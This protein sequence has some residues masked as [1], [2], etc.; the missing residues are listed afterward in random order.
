M[1]LTS[2]TIPSMIGGVSQQ[3]ASVRLMSQIEDALNCDLSPAR[4]AGPRPP[5]QF[6]NVLGSDIPDNA[7]FHSIIRDSRERYIVA[8]YPGRVRV[9]NHETGKEYVVIT[10]QPSL[11]YLTTQQNPW[12]S[13]R[14]VTVDDYT[15]IVNRD[16]RVAMAATLTP[17]SVVGSVQTFE[18]LPKVTD[19]YD[20]IG[21]IY[22]VRGD[23]QNSFDN[24]FVQMEST[25]VWREVPC[26]GQKGTLDKTTMPHGLKRVPDSIN[27]DG[28][29]FTYG[30]LD[31]DTRY[32]GDDDSSPAPSIVG[33]RL[34]D[35]FFHRDRLGLVA[36][37]G[38]VVMSEIGHYFNFW[39]T[40]VTSLLD[41][42]VIDVNAP[43][44]GVAEMLHVCAYQKA[45]MIFASGKTSMFQLTGT[46]TLTPK[47]VKIDPVTTYGV[48][49][50]IKPLLAASSLF[51]V[52]DNAAKPWSTVR[53]Y[54]VSDDTVTP[55]AANITAHVP[56]Y[57]PGKTR[58]ME[59]AS[60]ADMLFL[61]HQSPAGPQ[62]FVHQYKW[63]GDEKQQSAWHP[64]NLVGTGAVVHMH[65]IG[66]DL[67]LVTKAP[68]GGVE[69]LKMDLGNSPT[70][71]LISSAFDI[72]LDRRQAAQPVYQAFGNYTDIT[73]PLVLPTLTALTVLKTTDW[74]SSGTYLDLRSA[75][76]VN[77]G[78]TIRLPGRVD[79][80]R[81]VVGYRYNRSVTL[82]QQFTRD[83][84][85]VAKLIG[86][87]Q[88]KRMTVRFN[89]TAFF[90]TQVTPKG[91]NTATDSMVPQLESTFAARSAGDA[92]FLTNTPQVQ[93]GTYSFLVASRSDQVNV[94]FVTDSPYPAWFQSVQWEGLYTS[95][96]Q[97]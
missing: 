40:T 80:G 56:A 48:S 62:V 95:K 72:H 23:S 36:S 61:A 46:P 5:A 42:D 64:W 10:D 86:R 30:P 96:V 94:S 35:V 32:A 45:L 12:E 82:S 38:N 22:E 53:E 1:P 87:L 71:P 58:C 44:E 19:H 24:Y 63:Q 17:G 68:G 75:T 20:R 67:Y 54:F 65:A 85:N 14:A 88:I 29:Y 47:T 18:D 91:R 37:A 2:G 7:F 78:Q 31:Y 28:F 3:D 6:V 11:S 51:F 69:L 39:R 43:T 70:Y 41:S 16:V 81:V 50:T 59:A 79:T 27:P 57:V 73:V 74:P 34:G 9:F 8:I 76:L 55:E 97:Q 13:L 66:T 89:D 33:Q 25:M 15:F 93:S 92:A 21:S 60:D 49:P 4:G 26:P 52:D 77:G 84:N 90:K 83:Q